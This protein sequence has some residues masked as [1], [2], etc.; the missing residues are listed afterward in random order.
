MHILLLVLG[1]LCR[2]AR[3]G[4]QR[5]VSVGQRVFVERLCIGGRQITA[6]VGTESFSSL[7]QEMRVLSISR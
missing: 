4:H 3:E 7:A 1:V 2:R 5:V 6:V